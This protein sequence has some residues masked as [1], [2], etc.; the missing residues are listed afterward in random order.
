M[1]WEPDIHILGSSWDGWSIL[2][3]SR[4]PGHL[5]L[6][7]PARIS[8]CRILRV[9]EPWASAFIND[10]RWPAKNKPPRAG[11]EFGL[12][13]ALNVAACQA[14]RGESKPLLSSRAP[15]SAAL[16]IARRTIIQNVAETQGFSSQ[17]GT[18]H[19]GASEISPKQP[20]NLTPRAKPKIQGAGT[21][22]L[23]TRQDF[24]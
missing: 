17:V 22:P 24:Y 10:D 1:G 5:F 7:Y 13:N 20:R 11:G 2:K 15:S 3:K 18:T 4:I 16:S 12:K 9:P 8:P 14:I 23:P 19:G 6:V 21:H